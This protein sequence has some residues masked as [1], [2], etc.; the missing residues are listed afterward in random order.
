M[1]VNTTSSPFG[2]RS[3][4]RV[5]IA[6][7]LL[8]ESYSRELARILGSGLSVVQ[9]AVRSLELD[10]LIAARAVG[11]TRVYALNPG[12]FAAKQVQGLTRRLAEADE[13]LRRRVGTRRSRPRRGGKPL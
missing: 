11:R 5:M 7:E 13:D 8:G 2:S 9:K 4:T 3:R 10:G 6:L 12:Y 1:K